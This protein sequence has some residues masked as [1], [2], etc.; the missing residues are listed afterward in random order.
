[1]RKRLPAFIIITALLLLAALI[2]ASTALVILL[3]VVVLYGLLSLISLCFFRSRVHLRL[4]TPATQHI[5]EPV[6]I[7]LQGH[8]ATIFLTVPIRAE[9]LI[10]NLLT[11]ETQIQYVDLLL[12]PRHLTESKFMF[13]ETNCGRILLSVKKQ[14][15]KDP[16]GIFKMDT[17]P[18]SR[19]TDVETLILP[20]LLPPDMTDTVQNRYNPAS[21]RYSPDKSGSD[22]S[23]VFGLRN[24]RPGD[25]L[26]QIHWKLTA[27]T[28]GL[29]VRIPSEP[30][31]NKI[32]VLLFNAISTKTSDHKSPS[33]KTR[34]GLASLALSLSAGLNARGE[35]HFVC[36][37]DKKSRRFPVFPV[38]NES[39]LWDAA[40]ALLGNG[41]PEIS[42]AELAE[43]IDTAEQNN[44]SDIYLI[45]SEAE[46]ISELL[47]EY[48]NVTVF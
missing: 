7:T 45:A 28:G 47:F 1:M 24:Y 25:S 40:Y 31:V 44:Y 18:D 34:S 21:F 3:L 8:T 22:P 9:I 12:K 30:V 42:D 5:D 35:P 36:C 33:P 13:S 26:K 46:S 23:E 48:S 16:L 38:T 14:V 43:L 37:F 20:D 17:S 15:V 4:L 32:C 11:D 2:T 27:K 39:E 41:F 29:T 19:C 6:T 10:R